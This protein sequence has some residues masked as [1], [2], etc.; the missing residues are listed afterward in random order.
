[1]TILVLSTVDLGLKLK[2]PV[3]EKGELSLVNTTTSTY[4]LINLSSSFLLLSLISQTKNK[5]RNKERKKKI[6]SINHYKKKSCHHPDSPTSHH[7]FSSPK[8]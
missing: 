4:Q 3:F 7:P 8:P 5:S 6:H 1:M 2:S